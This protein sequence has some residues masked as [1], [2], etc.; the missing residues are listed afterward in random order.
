VNMNVLNNNP[1]LYAA[2]EL[3]QRIHLL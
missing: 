1:V 3:G 2:T